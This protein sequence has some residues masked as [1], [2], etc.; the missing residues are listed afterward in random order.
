M[1]DDKLFDATALVAGINLRNRV[2]MAPMT[3]W[4]ANDDG[5]VSDEEEAYYRRRAKDVGLVITGC[6]HVQTNGV[7]FTGEFA[8]H[9]DRFIPSLSRLARGAKS[10]G[11]PAILQLFHAGVKTSPALVSDIVA[12]SAVEGEAGPF[13]PASIP[14]ALT[15]E[16]I[17][18]V[19]QA[20]A[21]ATRRAILAGFDGIELHGAHG[22]LI[23]NFFSLHFNRREDRWGGSLE[24]RMRFPLAVVDAVREAIALSAD[25]PF[26]LGYRI[27]VD[28]AVAT[29]LRIADSLQLVDRL[30]EHDV[31]YIHVSLGSALDQRPVDDDTGRSIVSLVHERIANRVPLIAAGGIRTPDQ[32]R[33][34]IAS[35]LSLVAIGQALVM[36]PGWVAQARDGQDHAIAASIAAAD[37]SRLAIPPKLWAIIDAT[38]GWFNITE[39]PVP[40]MQQVTDHEHQL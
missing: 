9:D 19:V 32:A 6:T 2:V 27:S 5:T 37:I 14:R 24:N 30:I 12:A 34:G 39:Q 23:Q 22:F 3:T 28:E 33:Q 29:G 35:G 17:L 26:A 10:G 15:D 25:R 36:D 38:P 31:S 1:N 4:A 11:A 16:E 13:A 40:Q 18:E 20:F 21:D 8:A 7:G